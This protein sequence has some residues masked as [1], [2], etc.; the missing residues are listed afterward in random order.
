MVDTSKLKRLKIILKKEGKTLS[1]YDVEKLSQAI[2]E[3]G[4]KNFV[5]GLKH[6]TENHF[7]EAVK[8][9]QLSDCRDAPLIIALLS[10][11]VG[12]TFMFEEYKNEKSEKDCLNKLGVDVYCRLSDKEILLTKENL[13][14]IADLLK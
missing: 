13:N 6:I 3:I 14:K 9:F 12:D 11:K 7:T 5:T 8:W 10:L 1:H 2:K 4:L